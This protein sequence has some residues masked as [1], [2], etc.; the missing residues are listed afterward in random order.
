MSLELIVVGYREVSFSTTMAFMAMASAL[1]T[2]RPDYSGFLPINAVSFGTRSH[3]FVDMFTLV[4]MSGF[5]LLV[6]L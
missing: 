4:W 5:M 6:L 1:N 3:A 2:D